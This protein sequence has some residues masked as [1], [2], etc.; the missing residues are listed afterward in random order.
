MTQKRA[1]FYID[2]FNLYYAA[3]RPK[4]HLKWLNLKAL[5]D[6]IVHEDTTVVCVKYFTSRVLGSASKSKRQNVY[7]IVLKTVSQIKITFGNLV[8]RKESGNMSRAEQTRLNLTEQSKR[9]IKGQEVA[10]NT[11]EEKGTDV[12][13]ASHL[14]YDACNDEFDIAYVITN[15]TDFVEPIRMVKEDL[16]K[17]VVIV[18]ARRFRY[19]EEDEQD[20]EKKKPRIPVPDITL[21]NAASDVYYIKNSLFIASQFPDEIQIENGD[22]ISRPTNWREIVK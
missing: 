18:A 6:G 16:G 12:N 1:I 10:I 15:D 7:F 13:L 20:V 3:L 9:N 17:T 2:G 5:A 22:I 11:F 4:P 8:K 19:H 21:K 14:I